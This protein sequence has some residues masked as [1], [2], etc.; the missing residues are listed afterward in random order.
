MLAKHKVAG[1][2]P[3]TRSNPPYRLPFGPTVKH[4]VLDAVH[5]P[6]KFATSNRHK[7]DEARAILAGYGIAV[8]MAAMEL[9]EIQ[10]ETLEEIAAEK[11]REASRRLD[12][13]ALVEDTGLFIDRLRGFPG[14]YSAYV[15]RTLGN[16]GVLRLLEAAEDRGAA[17]R[18]VFAYCR[19]G[20]S[21]ECFPSAVPGTIAPAC[22]GGG[23]GY[24]PIF[25]AEGASGR[26][27]GELGSDKNRLSHRRLAL[28]RL[29]GWLRN[30]LTE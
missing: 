23:W 26:T 17:F 6:L 28:E 9:R 14:P 10:A 29:A 27:Y 3:V 24:D 12:G 16:Q 5:G 21:P 18:S 13:P 7:F 2:T 25:V 15:F 8:E 4:P 30:S 22:R 11:A 19:P 20:G 1:S